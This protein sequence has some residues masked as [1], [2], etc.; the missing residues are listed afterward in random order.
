MDRRNFMKKMV[1]GG[2]IVGS[3]LDFVYAGKNDITEDMPIIKTMKDTEYFKEKI[4]NKDNRMFFSCSNLNN[5][6]IYYGEKKYYKEVNG[7]QRA[8]LSKEEYK[9]EPYEIWTCPGINLSSD[10]IKRS[11][12][13]IIKEKIYN[14]LNTANCLLE[15]LKKDNILVD[16]IKW[17]DYDDKLDMEDLISFLNSKR[18]KVCNKNE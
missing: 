6:Q 10:E 4:L 14:T 17:P 11:L 18:G 2:T 3:N 5:F 15:E 7:N 13:A 8:G 9:L 12:L 1:I 16:D